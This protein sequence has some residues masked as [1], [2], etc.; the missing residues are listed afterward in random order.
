M[1]PLP[2]GQGSLRPVLGPDLTV[3]VIAAGV[4]DD[5]HLLIAPGVFGPDGVGAADRRIDR[6]AM[7]AVVAGTRRLENDVWVGY[8]NAATRRKLV[9]R[10]TGA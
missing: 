4:W 9:T 2:Q 7:D 8:L 1:R 10:V 5:M 6:G 3:A